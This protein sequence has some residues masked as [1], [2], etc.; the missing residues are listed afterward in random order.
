LMVSITGEQLLLI[1]TYKV[2]NEGK[3]H[4]WSTI[5]GFENNITWLHLQR[6]WWVV[7]L[8]YY[9]TISFYLPRRHTMC[10]HLSV[11]DMIKIWF[12]CL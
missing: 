1:A 10:A 8:V 7:M 2:K 4:F 11:D 9:H 6:L 5:I 12:A 3:K